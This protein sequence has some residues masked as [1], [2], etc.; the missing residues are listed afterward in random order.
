[1]RNPYHSEKD[2]RR[3]R[4]RALTWG[5]VIH[6][7]VISGLFWQQQRVAEQAKQDELRFTSGGGGGGE[8]EPDEMLQFGP[9][10]NPPEGEI[11]RHNSMEFTLLDIQVYNDLA[12]AIPTIQ[13]EEPKPVVR[14]KK[15]NKKT[16]TIVA[17]NLPT[18]WVRRGTGPGSGGG[19]GGGS[20]GGIGKSTGYSI[21]WGGTG[22]RRLL[23]GLIPKYPDGTDKQMAVVLQFS[24]LPDGTVEGIVPTRKTDQ[25]LENAAVKALHTWRFEPLPSEMGARTQSGKVSFNFRQEH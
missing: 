9:Q 7:L 14:T 19:A 23:S 21:D 22:G 17:E 3:I 6:S 5:L 16:Q 1:M 10:S 2:F 25:L 12:N 15:K 20:G 11:A 24:V 13:K 8:G 4:L 18:R